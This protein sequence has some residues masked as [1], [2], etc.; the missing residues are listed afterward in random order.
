MNAIVYTSNTGS[1]ARYAALLAQET[2][3]PVFSSAEAKKS[4]PA[5]SDILYLGWLMANSIKGYKGADKRYKISA[6]CA[7]GM[8]PTGSQTETVRK[9]NAVPAHTPLFTLQGSFDIQKL[10]GPYKAMMNVMIKTAGKGLENKTDRTPEE[11]ALLE[12]LVHGGDHV[13][14]EHLG[15]VLDWYHR[16]QNGGTR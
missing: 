5:G 1:T 14:T 12:I 3:L 16:V 2:G 10:R 6:V 8:M 9:H 15:A 4:L 11:D 13:S 7:V